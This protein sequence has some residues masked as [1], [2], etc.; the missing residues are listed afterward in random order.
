M[1]R[2]VI[3]IFTIFIT[4]LGIAY[5]SHN[6]MVEYFEIV[7]SEKVTEVDN[8]IIWK[9]T[10]LVKPKYWRSLYDEEYHKHFYI[11]E[12]SENDKTYIYAYYED[13]KWVGNGYSQ[14]RLRFIWE[15]FKDEQYLM[16]LIQPTGE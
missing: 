6:S 7:E 12:F 5:L 11:K 4:L 2:N 13:M 16:K 1:K 10:V 15:K 14:I 3:T 8:N 9:V